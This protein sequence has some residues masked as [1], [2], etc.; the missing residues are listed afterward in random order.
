MHRFFVGVDRKVFPLVIIRCVIT[1]KAKNLN[2]N[3]KKASMFL[4][5]YRN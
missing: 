2:K 4:E 1:L 5:K 3:V